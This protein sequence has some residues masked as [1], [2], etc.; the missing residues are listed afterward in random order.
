MLGNYAYQTRPDLGEKKE[1][2][3]PRVSPPTPT[4]DARPPDVVRFRASSLR[5][6]A[7]HLFP[8]PILTD[9][10]SFE[11]AIWF[12]LVKSMLT[13]S[14]MLADPANGVCLDYVDWFLVDH[15]L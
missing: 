5:Y 11:T 8:G 4:V 7:S 9:V 6:T 15:D 13:P 1:K 12:N 10:W 14:W 3:P 2:P